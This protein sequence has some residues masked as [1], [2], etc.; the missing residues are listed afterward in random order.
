MLKVN[1]PFNETT[2]ESIQQEQADTENQVARLAT[3]ISIH[4]EDENIHIAGGRNDAL[5]THTLDAHYG[6]GTVEVLRWL[7]QTAQQDQLQFIAATFQED[8]FKDFLSKLWLQEDIVPYPV[9]K[10][11]SAAQRTL[12]EQVRDVAS[13]FDE[14]NIVH[15]H[16]MANREVEIA[17]LVTLED[18]QQTVSQA[19][20]ALLTKLAHAFEGKR[21]VF[22]SAT[23]QGGGVALMRHALIRLMRLLNVDAHWHILV[24]KKEVFDI[25]KAKFHNV[26]QAVAKPGT[27]L[28]EEDKAI[29]NEW[30]KEN[31][32][33]LQDVFGSADV[34]V[35]DDPQPSGLIPHILQVNPKCKII[36]RS[37]IQ[38]VA[39]LASQP[40][41][42]QYTTWSFLWENIQWA[43]Y[44]VSHPMKMFIPDNVPAEK[45]FSM[46]ATTDALDGLNKP[47]TE[48]Q[49]ST[50][51]QLF[52][53]LLLQNGQTPL[54]E[55]RPYIIQVARFDPS[56]GIP[57][58]LDAY[59]KLRV[60]LEEQ[61]EPVPQ[62][63]ITGNGSVDDPDGVPVYNLVMSILAS[64]PYAH[65]SN[66]I[67]VVR[68]PHRDQILNTL[69]RKSE[70]VLQLSTKEGFEVKVTEALMKGK[71]VI[72]YNV[73]G[74]PLQ[75]EDGFT[76]YLVEVGNTTQVAHHLYTLLT[77][78]TTYWQMSEAAAQRA[79]KDYLTIPNAICWLYL[80]LQLLSGEKL[81]GQ[82][83]WVKALAENASEQ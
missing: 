44:F 12:E 54:D 68:L 64:E 79:G 47:L 16:I 74:I 57:D 48:E 60:M 11:A 6:D 29:Y 51:M 66:D 26:L 24:P 34:I 61:N 63:V 65:F 62:L 1:I 43:D 33:V 35:I 42:P 83:R 53:A 70:V 22:I 55:A 77:D 31:A 19:E 21:L 13:R 80:A 81:E 3:Y 7:H 76:G 41:T 15:P 69:L 14:N 28:T 39:S 23:P 45:V 46:P 59:R 67:K 5:I 4:A 49:M 36:Y 58:V 10:E 71:P 56:K 32:F 8:R 78:A 50:Y 72:A 27:E 9:R 75:I 40:G 18:Y 73:G 17:E 20:F 82:Y 38:L 2:I 25:T 52:N 30:M 37:H